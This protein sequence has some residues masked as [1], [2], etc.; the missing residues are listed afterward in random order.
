M[1]GGG[2]QGELGGQHLVLLTALE[3]ATEM[4][5][6]PLSRDLHDGQMSCGG[7]YWLCFAIVP[8]PSTRSLWE[9]HYPRDAAQ[10]SLSSQV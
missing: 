2:L 6:G 3:D 4:A 5:L 8:C 7:K 1:Q 9:C 10:P